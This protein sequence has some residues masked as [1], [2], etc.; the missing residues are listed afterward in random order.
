MGETL[1]QMSAT[2]TMVTDESK[3]IDL[4]S[5]AVRKAIQTIPDRLSI[6]IP[7]FLGGTPHYLDRYVDPANKYLPQVDATN[8]AEG[9]L[10]AYILASR[11]SVQ[12]IAC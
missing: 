8:Y 3:V 2:E 11:V 9:E 7:Y 6:H 12:E 4:A 1:Q 5:M 10:P